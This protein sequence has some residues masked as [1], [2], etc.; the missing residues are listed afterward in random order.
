MSTID[1]DDDND[2]DTDDDDV[3]DDVTNDGTSIESKKRSQLFGG[4][5][6]ACWGF[7]YWRLIHEVWGALNREEG[8][9]A[10]S[11]TVIG[12]SCST[13]V[14]L[15]PVPAG[16]GCLG[17]RHPGLVQ[18]RQG[19]QAGGRH[20]AHR[21]PVEFILHVRSVLRVP[22][23]GELMDQRHSRHSDRSKCGRK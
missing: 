18:R 11:G 8:A 5:L 22:S 7:C 13:F 9:S 3:S 20:Q 15:E 21:A 16:L 23:P 14:S 4:D 1:D 6:E 10:E 12:S 19:G 17:R 2:Y